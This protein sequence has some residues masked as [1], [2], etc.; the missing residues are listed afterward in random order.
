MNSAEKKD[1]LEIITG[2][3]PGEGTAEQE[4]N[5]EQEFMKNF[6]PIPDHRRAL[7]PNMLL[8]L[9]GRGAGKT[10]LFRLLSFENAREALAIHQD[11]NHSLRFLDQ[12]S[13]VPGYGRPQQQGKM[14]PSP[15]S[16][17]EFSKTADVIDW[18][19]FWMGL[20]IGMLLRQNDES[21][22]EE[23][24]GLISVNVREVLTKEL[25]RL[26]SWHPIV[27]AEFEDLNFFLDKLDDEMVKVDHWLFMT[28]DELDKL[29]VTHARLAA[30]IR[31]L[32]AF[33]LDRWRRW[34]RI[35]PKIFLRTDLFG[36]EFLGF[37]DASKLQPHLIRL[38]WQTPWLYQL[39]MKRLANAGQELLAYLNEIPGL[40]VGQKPN[41]GYIPGTDEKLYQELMKKMVGHFMGKDAKKGIT[42]RWIPNH[43][44]D[45]NNRISPRSFL[46]MFALAAKQELERFDEKQLPENRLLQ[47]THLQGALMETSEAR[48]RELAVEE[49]PWLNDLKPNFEG[50]E[51]PAP[52]A[53]LL[54][55]IRNTTW[56]QE[57]K[58][59]ASN[60]EDILKYL[61]KLGILESR[62]DGRLNMPDIYLY[63]FKMKRRGGIRRPK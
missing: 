4:S 58:K 21:I 15:E 56:V 25:S 34:E 8:V 12:A 10:Q 33:W 23:L 14:Y 11:R 7:D 63:G 19:A 43:L 42:Y 47:P 52:K 16:V 50:I 22:P 13:W 29:T 36:A 3:A 20:L 62:T 61:L 54:Q 9:G 57:E 44:Q 38:E 53:I 1:L 30:P 37:P 49:Y 35:R 55:A 6:M 60:P 48:I 59:P 5:D 41:L 26:K 27:K 31:E 45:A 40:I 2:I 28:Y 46:K 39:L 18:R 17:E 51:V 32:L 24:L